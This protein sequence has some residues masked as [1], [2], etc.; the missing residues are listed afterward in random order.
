MNDQGVWAVECAR[1]LL[2]STLATVLVTLILAVPFVLQWGLNGA[3]LSLILGRVVGLSY[4]SFKFFRASISSPQVSLLNTQ[5]L[6][7]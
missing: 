6:P 1:W 2:H 5:G 7:Q 3:A 4:Q